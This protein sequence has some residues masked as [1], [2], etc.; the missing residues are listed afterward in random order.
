MPRMPVLFVGH[1]SPMNAVE[2]TEFTREWARLPDHIPAPKAIL[3]I[4]A[5]W[6]TRGLRVTDAAQL[7]MV[8]DM[9]GFPEELYRIVYPA[10]GAPEL[11]HRAAAL[12]SGT[13]VK[14]DNTWGLDHGAWTVLHRMYPQAQ[15][16]V[17]QLSVDGTAP[18]EAQLA[19]GQK[20]ADLRNE[21]VL[22]LGSGNVVHNLR[23]VGWDMA[24]GYP[25]A[26]E[27]DRYV[28]EHIEASDFDAVVRYAGTGNS[29]RR[30]VPSPD[31]FYPLL[32]V[33]GAVA[34]E[35]RVT[36]FNDARVMGSL[37]MTGY[38]FRDSSAD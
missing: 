7:R 4:S 9:Y 34:P 21:G 13:A 3:V 12:L 31:H 35:D 1:G 29:A 19:V 15:Y 36:V 30:A 26:D 23:E 20:L 24:G 14:I 25:W 5:H 2:D 16:P 22:I 6:F 8:Y 38:L 27:F 17:C 33:L 28:R 32:S 11:A 10:P 18:A 37:S